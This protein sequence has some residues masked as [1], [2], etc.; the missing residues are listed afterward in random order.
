VTQTAAFMTESTLSNTYGGATAV[1]LE[2]TTTINPLAAN[3]MAI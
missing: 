1:P 2:I 3:Q